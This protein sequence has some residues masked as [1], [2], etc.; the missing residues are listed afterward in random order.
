M[1]FLR[2]LLYDDPSRPDVV[3]RWAGLPTDSR[4]I[5]LEPRYM[6]DAAGA[7][8]VDA[9]DETDSAERTEQRPADPAVDTETLS[10]LE[11]VERAPAKVATPAA[12]VEIAVIDAAVEGADGIVAA[13]HSGGTEVI[14]LSA[15]RDGV[16]QLAEALAGRR[17]IGAIHLFTHGDDGSLH[18]GNTT[19]HA[20]T[21]PQY[22]A[23][24]ATIGDALAAH[25]DLLVYGCDVAR[26]AD[27]RQ[28]LSDLARATTADAA[29]S[30]GPTG[31]T[32]LGGDWDLEIVSGSMEARTVAAIGFAGRLDD[33]ATWVVDIATDDAAD[34]G[35]VNADM[36]DNGG[37]SLREAIHYA[38]G[39]DTIT[40]GDGTGAVF[41]ETG[42]TSNNVIIT[43][44]ENLGPLVID[45]S[46]MIDGDL[47]N[48]DI[49]DVTISGNN[50]VRVLEVNGGH[51]VTLDGLVITKGYTDS[52]PGGGIYVRGSSAALT[53]QDSTIH[54]NTAGDD[55][56]GYDGGGLYARDAAVT[57]IGSTIHDNYA[58]ANGGGIMARYGS[59]HIANST[60]SSNGARDFGGSLS[61][62]E[63]TTQVTNTTIAD[64]YAGNKG[65]GIHIDG[66]FANVTNSTIAN[67]YSHVGGAVH[68]SYASVDLRNSVIAGNATQSGH[69]AYADIDKGPNASI[70]AYHSLTQTDTTS[71]LSS[72]DSGF[73]FGLDPR[74]DPAG[75]ADNGGGTLTI[76]LQATSPVLNRGSNAFLPQDDLDLD[77]NGI[78]PETLSV[79][80]RGPATLRSVGAAVDMG[81]FE[82][83]ADLNTQP[84]VIGLGDQAVDM[85]SAWGPVSLTIDDLETEEAVLTLSVASDNQTLVPQGAISVTGRNEIREIEI[86]PATG[87]VGIANITLTIDDGT[88]TAHHSFALTVLDSANLVVTTVADEE[89]N[90]GS[91]AADAVDGGGLSLRE[92]VAYVS[93]GGTI[94]FDGTL[95]GQSLS[96]SQGQI[97]IERSMTIDGG[98]AVTVDA[99]GNSRHFHQ[100]DGGVGSVFTLTGI[101][102][103]HGAAPSGNGGSILTSQD[104]GSLVLDDVTIRDSYAKSGG[105]IKFN[106]GTPGASLQIFNSSFHDNQATHHAAGAIQARRAPGGVTID[107]TEFIGNTAIRTDATTGHGGALR[108]NKHESAGIF[109]VRISDSTFINNEASRSGG[110][111]S[112]RHIGTLTIANSSFSGNTSHFGGA[113]ISGDADLVIEAGTTITDNSADN[114]GGGVYVRSDGE[115]TAVTLMNATLQGNDAGPGGFGGGLAFHGTQS[116]D[117]LDILDSLIDHNV[118]DAGGGGVKVSGIGLTAHIVRT[119]ISNNEA[120]GDGANGGGLLVEGASVTMT[121]S[122]LGFNDAR[123]DGAGIQVEGTVTLINSTV[124]S[125]TAV[126]T[127]GG[128]FIAAGHM[129]ALYSST[130]ALNEATDGGGVFVENGAVTLDNTLI[131]ANTVS[132]GHRDVVRAGPH[133]SIT[134]RSSLIE[135]G[136]S[137]HITDHGG[138]LF[139]TPGLSSN[140]LQSLGKGPQV[141]ALAAGSNAINAGDNALLPADRQ[142]L[143]DD[144][145]LDEAVPVDQRGPGYDRIVDT[146]VDIG[147]F[148]FSGTPLITSIS[149]QIVAVGGSTGTL[150]FLV[151]DPDGSIETLSI[152]A[153]SDNQTLVPNANLSL[154]AINR[155]DREVSVQTAA[156][157]TGMAT[158]TLSVDDGTNV[159][160]T[161]FVITVAVPETDVE[162]DDYTDTSA[163]TGSVSVGGN[164][165]GMID[166]PDDVD[167]FALSLTAGETVRVDVSG[168]GGDDGLSDTVLA[169]FAPDALTPIAVNDQR[170]IDDNFSTVIF[171]ADVAGTYFVSAQGYESTTGR[172]TIDVLAQTVVDDHAR[173]TST[174][175][176]VRVGETVNG[177]LEQAGDRDWFAL[178]LSFGQTIDI[179]LL[180]FD[181]GVGTLEDPLL[182]VIGSQ[183]NL[184]AENNN[185][186]ETTFESFLTFTAQTTGRYYVSVGSAADVGHGTYAIEVTSVASG[187]VNTAIDEQGCA[188]ILTDVTDG[189]GF[190]LR[191]AMTWIPEGDTILI[192]RVLAGDIL[193]LDTPVIVQTSH[194]LD[195]SAADDFTIAGQDIIL[196]VDATL[197]IHLDTAEDVFRVVSDVAHD[198][199]ADLG[200]RLEK[201]GDGTLILESDDIRFSGVTEVLGGVLVVDGVLTNVDNAVVLASGSN[202]QLAGTG[203]IAGS[204]TA[205][206]G[207]TIAPGKSP[208]QLATGN[209][210]LEPGSS[211]EIEIH[212]PT[213]GTDYDQVVVT[214]TVSIDNASLDL[215]FDPDFRSSLGDTFVLVDND[216]T[217]AVSGMFQ[218]MAEGYSTTINGRPYILSY[219]DGD[220]NDVTLT[221]A[222]LIT[223]SD[224]ED[225]AYAESVVDTPQ[226]LAPNVNVTTNLETFDGITVRL[227]YTTTPDPTDQLGIGAFGPVT[228]VGPSIRHGGTEVATI[229]TGADGRDGSDLEITF[230]ADASDPEATNVLRALT[231]ASTA[232]EPVASRTIEVLVGTGGEIGT[233]QLTIMVTGENDNAP[234]APTDDD[235]SANEVVEDAAVGAKVGITALSTDADPGDT[236]T[237]HLADD[238]NGLFKI[239]ANT[240]IVTTAGTLDAEVS[241]Y[242]TI[243]VESF[244]GI[245]SNTTDFT[246]AVIDVNDNVPVL[247]ITDATVAEDAT[248]GTIILTADGFDPDADDT[249]T[250]SITGGSGASVFA[251]DANSGEISV[252]K[253]L[254]RERAMD[255]TLTIQMSDGTHAVADTVMIF[256][257]DVNDNA[258]TIT[259]SDIAVD[260]TVDVGIR[261]GQALVTDS[262]SQGQLVFSIIDGDPDGLFEIDATTGEVFLVAELDFES[263]SSH[264]LTI[265]I[266]DGRFAV[267][268]TMV[269]TVGDVNDIAPTVTIANITVPEDVAPG[270]FLEQAVGFDL[271][272]LAPLRYSIVS[273]NSD[274]LFTIDAVTGVLRTAGALDFESQTSHTIT[275]HVFDGQFIGV[276]VVVIT[277]T[278]VADTPTVVPQR[279]RADNPS[280]PLLPPPLRSDRQTPSD[281]MSSTAP[282]SV[283]SPVRL[284]ATNVDL[285]APPPVL[286]PSFN[287]AVDGVSGLGLDAVSD[288][289]TNVLDPTGES[290]LLPGLDGEGLLVATP[291]ALVPADQPPGAGGSEAPPPAP[292]PPVQGVPTPDTTAPSDPGTTGNTPTTLADDGASPG[293]GNVA[294]GTVVADADQS[295]ATGSVNGGSSNNGSD[296]TVP[297]SD[298]PGPFLF[299]VDALLSE[300]TDGQ[301]LRL[302]VSTETLQQAS[303]DAALQTLTEIGNAVEQAVGRLLQDVQ[304]GNA[305]NPGEMLRSLRALNLEGASAA[306]LVD[307]YYRALKDGRTQ[308]Y[309]GALSDIEDGGIPN[310]FTAFAGVDVTDT[311]FLPPITKPNVAL[312]IG[313]NEYGDGSI[314]NLNTPL[315]DV[316]AL[317]RMLEDSL[318]YQS[319]VLT[320]PGQTEIVQALAALST[321]LG[322]DSNLVVY[323]A[324]HGYLMEDSDIGYWLPTDASTQ[325]ADNW[326]STAHLSLFLREIEAR[327][328][329]V[330]SDSC[331]SGAFTSQFQVTADRRADAPA[332]TGEPLPRSVLA[333]SSGGEEPVRDD[334]TGGHSV[335]AAQLLSVLGEDAVGKTGFQVFA[336]VKDKVSLVTYQTP[337]YGGIVAAGHVPGSDFVFGSSLNVSEAGPAPADAATL[338]GSA[339]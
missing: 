124:A 240:G 24:L 74:L 310:P 309:S 79:D 256:V 231:F 250:Y 148:E 19:L 234:S 305:I 263:Q 335:F 60:L 42:E 27:G 116:G 306:T 15:D 271:D 71:I 196:G 36:A 333:M 277:V 46:L 89:A 312:L 65:G 165:S 184:V 57:I 327:Q 199:G 1:G 163:T 194:I 82:V 63:A 187:A 143:D 291:V 197:T 126:G 108:F 311:S 84:I 186:D 176:T 54:G 142:D 278:D 152:M 64:G 139:A 293:D 258:P 56:Y 154:N 156:G 276:D 273:G 51:R 332:Q 242:H 181:S 233:A 92:A 30:D 300:S 109:D 190:S 16:T 222:I 32:S 217:D 246:I 122:T 67:N 112:S 200:Q 284:P 272:T 214:G 205:Q 178:D 98:G 313:I 49:P 52:G 22:S 94:T 307:L 69:E 189:V 106:P 280:S 325:T 182:R 285:A 206:E 295:G 121:A 40:F 131:G 72:Y 303:L 10:L 2:R 29:A 102:L 261:L 212:G 188:S 227:T 20:G 162:P 146:T 3:R 104:G 299:D 59:L 331:Y 202:A 170:A 76:A 117:T 105:G 119:S 113:I 337:E 85:D 211:L 336:D 275:I 37:L 50:V 314:S 296:A 87:Q 237:Y 144:T 147:A 45:K 14:R 253:A 169:I 219:E 180:G 47:N 160:T 13:L 245:N 61:A 164:A 62:H 266:S 290:D 123:A 107:N 267:T 198:T 134:S 96:L 77:G 320:N 127:G 255:Y 7:A 287:R 297:E 269:V 8:T 232:A 308:A 138:T 130:I 218:G 70:N 249:L 185:A 114:H 140:G 34:G 12:A 6:F 88:D 166:F 323:Y 334:G 100:I 41:E 282:D 159:A 17:G 319:I 265:Q 168:T 11:A 330:I 339:P 201:T 247:T 257:G 81:A 260:E 93:D 298:A 155:N 329:L 158:I 283:L 322:E 99:Q 317:G 43:L 171:T 316:N 66:A 229:T 268:D 44:T 157:E 321:Q 111:I 221:D 251:I 175:A 238:S 141:I 304:S 172:Y 28:F 328:T 226:Q 324:G 338:P 9:A 153:T 241:D 33:S 279:S 173:D 150:S 25:G 75:L 132:T 86:V 248:L 274:G 326:I 318:D 133:A 4:L 145:N 38:Q 208:G 224:L 23:A 289:P 18:M 204:V 179:D 129:V 177:S 73:L 262:D 128:L 53:I 259:L 115:A 230:N 68:V 101:T 288:D 136:D 183:G 192:G 270:T 264:T 213:P 110:A 302:S 90:A 39:G 220:G 193:T 91:L 252:S 103:A 286:V 137:E 254:D 281:E 35:D 236:I 48:N 31:A 207:T 228:V 97:W 174:T 95:S 151:D 161:S 215:L 292:V 243:T 315:N 216:G 167:W 210:I 223:A 294:Q 135:D 239:D 26:T 125:N 225:P 209:L 235:N 191:E 244:D 195:V 55:E 21:L 203:K 149:D 83:Q 78:T 301:P 118:A 58:Y 5:A 80:Q 120:N